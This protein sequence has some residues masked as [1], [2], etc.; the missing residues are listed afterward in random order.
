M[1]LKSG[2]IGFDELLFGGFI[3]NS[4]ILVEGVPGA[5]KTTFGIQFIYEGIVKFNEPGIVI[6]F[7]ELPEQLYRDAANYGWD[8][9]K[10]EEQNMLRIICTSP[11]VILD[12]AFGFLESIVK[13]IGAKRLLLDSVT[14]FNMELTSIS[15]LR[16]SI[17]SLCNG[18][19]RMGLTSLLIKEVEDYT[20]FKASFEEFLVDTVIRLYFE[21]SFRSRRRYI[22]ILKSRGQDFVSG[23]YPFKLGDKGLEI[24][25]IL[26]MQKLPNKD[27]FSLTEKL[28]SGIDGLDNILGGGF[29]KSTTIMVEGASGTGK[30]VMGIHYL[31]EGIKNNEKCL[32]LATEESGDFIN[33]YINTFNINSESVSD[34]SSICI[35]DRIF[36]STSIEE[37]IDDVIAR[38]KANSVQRVVIDFVN[39]FVEFSDNFLTLKTMLRSLINFLN[40]MGCTTI[41]ILNEEQAGV[42]YPLKSIIQPLVQGEIY[43]SSSVRKGKRYRSLEVNKMKGQ[44]YISGKHLAEISSQGMSVFQRLGG[45]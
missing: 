22:E 29:L 32:L 23:K 20:A 43:L 38:V 4:S 12:N 10:L 39:T 13:E 5:G 30:T 19:K 14:Q 16:R 1:I 24:I 8:L 21:E 27:T 40:F 28:K 11:E 37:V 25:R 3:K 41:L 18:L 34:D 31:L 44:R 36:S 42:N 26:D 35:I 45:M 17:Y 9:R 15:D 33:K 2:I 6:T 7:E